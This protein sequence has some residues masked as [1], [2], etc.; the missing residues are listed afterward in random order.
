MFAVL[1]ID[2]VDVEEGMLIQFTAELEEDGKKEELVMSEKDFI[3][4]MN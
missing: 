2:A 4:A 1:W 3:W